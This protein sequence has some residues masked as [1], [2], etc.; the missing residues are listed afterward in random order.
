MPARTF[1]EIRL[2]NG[3]VGDPVLFID[4]PGTDDALLFDAGD[5]GRLDTKRL[6]DLAAVFI[7]HHHVDHFIG[8]DCIVRANLDRDKILHLFGP[9][10]TIARVYD[11]IKSYAW[12]FFAFQKLVL[13]IH[14]IVPGKERVGRLEYTRRLPVP[15]VVESDW[16]GPALY[17]TDD[18]RVE[19][20]F[21]DH[22]TPCLAFAL[23]EK[24]GY[25]P[26]PEKL[27]KGV[28]KRGP[29]VGE[30][31]NLLRAGAVLDTVVEIGGGRFTLET[32]AAN[33][34]SA[35][36]GARI[37]YVTDTHWSEEAKPGL[38]KLA[39][40][41]S[42]LYCDSYYAHAQLRQAVTHRHM[43]ATLTAEFAAQAKVEELI[44]MHFA[45]R[46]A[47]KYE[48]LIEEARRGFPCVSAEFL[49]E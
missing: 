3:S 29:W 20:A 49:V 37:A 28:L 18:L 31:L 47:G 21:A 24:V 5:N 38:L 22:T 45:P 19:C 44:L 23:V 8:L 7:T 39:Q 11:R 4:Y 13:E 33:Y 12:Q 14:E 10:G 30:V 9:D 16:S 25:H 17:E 48:M 36:R 26:D 1:S 32:L 15:E 6:G 2:V 42:R 27:D 40:K 35:S 41:A 43:T 46:Y 34:F